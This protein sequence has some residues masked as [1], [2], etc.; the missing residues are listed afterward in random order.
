MKSDTNEDIPVKSWRSVCSRIL[1]L[2][3]AA[4][5][6]GVVLQLVQIVV[7]DTLGI[8]RML[9]GFMWISLIVVPVT[10]SMAVSYFCHRDKANTHAG[11]IDAGVRHHR[12]PPSAVEREY[13]S[14]TS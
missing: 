13:I 12:N 7:F 8:D 3:G 1:E 2:V 6:F 14:C 10:T 9:G 11:S 5:V 4:F